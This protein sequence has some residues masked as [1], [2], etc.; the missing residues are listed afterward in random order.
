MELEEVVKKEIEKMEKVLKSVKIKNPMALEIYNLA[1][2]YL[3]DSKHF[4]NSGD[5]IRA[6]EAVVIS[7]AYIDSCLHFNFLEIPEELKDLFTV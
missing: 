1:L 6:F 4:F 3:I 7:W 2:S 5:L